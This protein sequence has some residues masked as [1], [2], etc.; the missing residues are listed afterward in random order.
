VQYVV[1]QKVKREE[2]GVKLRW[3]VALAVNWKY[4]SFRGGWMSLCRFT[5]LDKRYI[6]TTE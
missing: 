3:L 6:L 2:S 4:Q 5:V 1:Q